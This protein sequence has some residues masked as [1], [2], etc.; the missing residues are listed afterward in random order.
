MHATALTSDCGREVPPLS[1]P[2]PPVIPIGAHDHAAQREWEGWQ[3]HKGI[4]RYRNSLVKFN[5]AGEIKR[6]TLDALEPGQIIAQELIGPLVEAVRGYQRKTIE[7]LQGRARAGDND[8]TMTLLPAETL[9]AVTVLQALARCDAPT[10]FTGVAM[11]LGGRI[12]DE[13]DRAQWKA[14]EA[15]AAKERKETG[16]EPLVNLYRLMEKRNDK[17]DKRVFA[18]WAKKAPLFTRGAWKPAI[19]AE[20]GATLLGLLVGSNAWFEVTIKL[21]RNRQRRFFHMTDAGLR[22]VADR[23]NQNELMR[24]YLL[25]MI[26]EPRDHEY[27]EVP[28]ISPEVA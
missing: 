7:G 1:P 27:V 19:R 23:H 9:A 26:C 22:W 24:P 17:V 3:T 2:P 13:F 6:K 16:A 11:A 8:W 28:F 5:E 20:V 12:Q 21:E 25:P 15:A 4:E 18:K 14:R 10:T